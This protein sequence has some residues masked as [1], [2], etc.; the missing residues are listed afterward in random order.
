MV[1][2]FEYKTMTS[3]LG[4]A[5]VHQMDPKEGYTHCHGHMTREVLSFKNTKGAH[6]DSLPP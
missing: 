2:I 3:T 6:N 5:K 4:N 1:N